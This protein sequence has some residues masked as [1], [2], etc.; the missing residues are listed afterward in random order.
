MKKL[1]F[2]LVC[3]GLLSCQS[4]EEKIA[5]LIKKEMFKTLYDFESYE[6]IETSKLDSAYTTI[7]QDPIIRGRAIEIIAT[8][9]IGNK[10]IKE[11]EEH[12][13]T[14]EIWGD[15]YTTRARNKV[16]EA[17]EELSKSVA[18]LEKI[19]QTV[20]AAQKVI[21]EESEKFVPSFMGWSVIHEFRCKTKGGNFDIGKYKYVFTPK[22]DE[23][24]YTI[25]LNSESETEI[26]SKIDEAL[27][28]KKE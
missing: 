28:E 9:E 4:R 6:P 14:I 23:I 16:N 5:D 2:V 24:L 19:V 20:A 1:V 17:R 22:L 3:V 18:V 12:V 25:D 7:Y 13:R 10:Y 15:S 26:R 8:M 21:K 27:A 11:C